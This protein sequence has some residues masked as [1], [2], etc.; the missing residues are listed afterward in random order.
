[1]IPARDSDAT[2]ARSAMPE[3]P[4]FLP[5]ASF[6]FCPR[7]GHPASEQPQV[8]FCPE[9]RAENLPGATFCN[10]CGSKLA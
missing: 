10:Q 2:I 3:T 5:S 1:M 8:Q 9:C 7:C 4:A 6:R